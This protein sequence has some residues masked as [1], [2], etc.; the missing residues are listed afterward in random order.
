MG[1]HDLLLER[2]LRDLELDG[3]RVEEHWIGSYGGLL[4]LM[5]GD[6][7]VA[8]IHLL[9]PATMEYNAPVVREMFPAGEVALVRGYEREVGWVFRKETDFHE[10][11][12][13][14]GEFA[15]ANR[16]RGSG[17]RILIDRLLSKLAAESGVR[18]VDIRRSVRGYGREYSTHTAT[19]RAVAE[20]RADV[21]VSIRPVAA[22]YGLEFRT[23]G[24]ERY[25]F[26]LRE[27][28]PKKPIE[29]L[30]RLIRGL[31]GKISIPGY[32]IPEDAGQRVL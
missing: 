32:R 5:M 10:E 22:L 26:V 31:P 18:P 1:S 9:D 3:Y 29:A 25:D 12:L 15:L 30:L 20:G 8:G 14:R 11:G 16:N 4:S 2:L 24:W 13:L 6:A 21:T 23:I 28:A 27:G 17:T 19:C 7:D